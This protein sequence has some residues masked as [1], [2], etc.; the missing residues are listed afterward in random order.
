MIF[1]CRL[2]NDN[3]IAILFYVD[4]I[5]VYVR[6]KLIEWPIPHRKKFRFCNIVNINHA[7]YHFRENILI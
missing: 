7:Q 1:A 3:I 5:L 6:N 4:G 2:L